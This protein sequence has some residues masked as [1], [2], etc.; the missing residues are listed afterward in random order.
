M[1]K[2]QDYMRNKNLVYEITHDYKKKEQKVA[3]SEQIMTTKKQQF[4]PWNKSRIQKEQ[5]FSVCE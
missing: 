5:K 2:Y 1:N 3:F 4:R